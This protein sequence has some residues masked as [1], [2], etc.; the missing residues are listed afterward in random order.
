[1]AYRSF[2][3]LDLVRFGVGLGLARAAMEGFEVGA[4]VGGGG[5]ARLG[6]TLLVRVEVGCCFGE[7]GEGFALR[8]LVCGGRGACGWLGLRLSCLVKAR[9]G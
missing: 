7:P 9:A 8:G 4:A 3:G 1:M 2:V 6:L 5:S